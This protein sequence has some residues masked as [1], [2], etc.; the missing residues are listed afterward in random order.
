MY[1]ANIFVNS[2]AL[3]TRIS[4]C[5]STQSKVKPVILCGNRKKLD[6]QGVSSKY[7][8]KCTVIM[9]NTIDILLKILQVYYSILIL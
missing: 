8:L 9:K 3:Q 7:G 2:I 6:A 4:V 5:L 1:I